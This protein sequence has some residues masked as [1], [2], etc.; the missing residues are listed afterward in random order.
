MVLEEKHEIISFIHMDVKRSRG[1]Q[2][3]FFFFQTHLGGSRPM[4]FMQ[5]LQVLRFKCFPQSRI[6]RSPIF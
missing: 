6:P 3:R 2:D 1:S 4:Q 5:A